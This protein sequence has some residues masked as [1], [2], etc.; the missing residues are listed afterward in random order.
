MPMFTKPKTK[1]KSGFTLIELL[2][3]IS[4][5]GLLSTLAVVA[6]NNA[7]VRSRDAKRTSDMSALLTAMQLFY[8]QYTSFDFTG[9]ANV[10]GNGANKVSTCNVAGQ[11]GLLDYMGGV[12][13][14]EDPITSVSAT[15]SA[16]SGAC[17]TC[18]PA[19]TAASTSD[20]FSIAFCLEGQSGSLA[21][22][23]HVVT[24]TGIR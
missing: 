11:G 16:T 21:A 12:G 6:L 5:I 14:I 9:A 22:G 1:A 10:C 7:R 23:A 4:I 17:A 13:S 3:V 24:P 8:D 19:F 18:D 20:T 2:V 15:C